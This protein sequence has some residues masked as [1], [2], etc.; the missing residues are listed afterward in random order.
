[1]HC[2][3]E[4]DFRPFDYDGLISRVLYENEINIHQV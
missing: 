1:L 4:F 2:D 3:V